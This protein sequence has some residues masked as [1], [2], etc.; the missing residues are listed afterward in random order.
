MLRSNRVLQKEQT[1]LFAMER[2]LVQLLPKIHEALNSLKVAAQMRN[3]IR[4]LQFDVNYSFQVEELHLKSQSV[5]STAS[6]GTSSSFNVNSNSTVTP[7]EHINRQHID[8]GLSL[9]KYCEVE[10]DSD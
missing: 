4:L 1:D 5:Q 7:N 10:S 2:K 6:Q 8:L 3:I 9:N